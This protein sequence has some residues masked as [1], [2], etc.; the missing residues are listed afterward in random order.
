MDLATITMQ[1]ANV[2]R[3]VKPDQ[4]DAPTPCRDWD[5]GTLTNHLLQVVTALDLAGRGQPVPSDLWE[6]D[7]PRD[8][9]GARFEE[10]A[11]GAVAAWETSPETVRIGS[12]EMPAGFAATMF[13]TDLV[14]HGWVSA[15]ATRDGFPLLGE[16]VAPRAGGS[17]AQQLLGLAGG[18]AG[19]VPTRH[20]AQLGRGVRVRRPPRLVQVPA[21]QVGLEREPDRRGQVVGVHIGPS[22][23]ACPAELAEE[24]PEVARTTRRPAPS[25][26][27]ARCSV[28]PSRAPPRRRA[29]RR[30][31][32]PGRTGPELRPVRLVHRQAGGQE[33]ALGEDE[34][35]HRLAGDEDQAAHA[36]AYAGFHHVERGHQVVA[37]DDVRC[38]PAHRGYR[39]C[40]HDGIERAAGQRLARRR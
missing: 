35:G 9:G 30:R 4:L 28:D 5:V 23:D 17:P 13:A 7:L 18:Y 11:R 14:I 21:G 10:T 38:V 20:G 31:A 15:V 39:R 34:A 33:R 2:V 40:V 16:V 22:G 36:S 32:S 12:A 3:G 25:S 24:G 37:E 26:A 29:A 6:R 8:D 19:G 1:T 27:A